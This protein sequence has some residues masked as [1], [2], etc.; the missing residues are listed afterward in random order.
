[1]PLSLYIPQQDMSLHKEPMNLEHQNNVL[2][3]YKSPRRIKPRIC[4]ENTAINSTLSKQLEFQFSIIFY[5]RFVLINL[6]VHGHRRE[7]SDLNKMEIY[8]VQIFIPL[9]YIDE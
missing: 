5:S 2:E 3:K 7:L 9:K 6:L 8:L 4:N 1:M